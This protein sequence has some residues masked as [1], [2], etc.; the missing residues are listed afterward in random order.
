MSDFP[1]KTQ[2]A[3]MRELAQCK[4]LLLEQSR[5]IETLRAQLDEAVDTLE[6]V[7]SAWTKQFERHGHAAP[8]WAKHARQT[9]VSL[10]CEPPQEPIEREC[11]GT[12][13]RTPHRS[14]CP[15]WRGKKGGAA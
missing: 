13:F 2:S 6:H 1:F 10:K 15:N 3:T 8:A 5:Q 12:F 11:C 14:T 9:I 4:A 7:V